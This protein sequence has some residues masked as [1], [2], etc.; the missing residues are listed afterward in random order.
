MERVEG[1]ESQVTLTV[2]C[3]FVVKERRSRDACR[4][5]AAGI[6]SLLLFIL[7]RHGR[8]TMKSFMFNTKL[9]DFSDGDGY[10]VGLLAVGLTSV[11][12]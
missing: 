5:V 2:G 7:Q 1:V 10:I 4:G 9:K 12:A 6:A 11:L 3:G 8:Q